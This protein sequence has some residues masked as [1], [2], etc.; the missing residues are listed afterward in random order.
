[1]YA[2]INREER[3]F[4]GLALVMC[5][6]L[7]WTAVMPVVTG[8]LIYIIIHDDELRKLV[9]G[10][11]SGVGIYAAKKIVDIMTKKYGKKIAVKLALRLTG[12]GVSLW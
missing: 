9:T 12:I 2:H 6:V 1:M 7:V 5:L 8:D 10:A 4:R 11:G 3:L